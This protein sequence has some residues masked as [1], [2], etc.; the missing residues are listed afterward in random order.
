VPQRAIVALVGM[1]ARQSGGSGGDEAAAVHT[2]CMEGLRLLCGDANLPHAHAAVRAGLVEQVLAVLRVHDA[3]DRVVLA[4]L[5]LLLQLVVSRDSSHNDIR[6]AVVAAHAV[7]IIVAAA[8]RRSAAVEESEMAS[9]IVAEAFAVLWGLACNSDVIRRD[10]IVDGVIE[11]AAHAIRP[12]ASST[13]RLILNKQALGT[14]RALAMYANGPDV[15]VARRMIACGAV[16]VAVDVLRHNVVLRVV[17]PGTFADEAADEASALLCNL[18]LTEPVA[19][20]LMAGDNLTVLQHAT[21]APGVSAHMCEHIAGVCFN[22]ASSRSIRVEEQ[23]E[24]EPEIE[25]LVPAVAVRRLVS[26]AAQCLVAF[27]GNVTV[28]GNACGALSSLMRLRS[29]CSAIVDAV[30]ETRAIEFLQRAV[31]DHTAT[32]VQR[33][34]SEAL[35]QLNM[36][37]AAAA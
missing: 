34:A 21:A 23:R 32:V 19:A 10:L 2:A 37:P 24:T 22:V 17:T 14:L 3:V 33:R 26:V 8:Q 25:G 29:L 16:R 12:L 15:S 5:S 11:Q 36:L 1:M 13:R 30:V 9:S 7:P 18:A 28:V 4:A 35:Q 6:A 20:E 27:P 31:A